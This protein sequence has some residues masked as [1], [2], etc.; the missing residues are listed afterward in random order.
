MF[1]KVIEFLSQTLIFLSRYHCNPML[2]RPLIFQ[3]MNYVR[4]NNQN[5][6]YQR[7]TSSDRKD[8]WIRHS[9]YLY[10]IECPVI[11]PKLLGPQQPILAPPLPC[12]Q[13]F[14]S[15]FSPLPHNLLFF[16]I[17]HNRC[18]F[19]YQSWANLCGS[20]L[21]CTANLQLLKAAELCEIPLLKNCMYLCL[22]LNSP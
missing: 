4:S 17:M 3:T 14:S 5:L 7:F 8:V 6:K 1:C 21:D 9:L 15:S 16:Q 11:F 10:E 18:T 2:Y 20:S 19:K 22:T 12:S 13:I